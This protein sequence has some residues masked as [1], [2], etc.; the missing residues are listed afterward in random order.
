[1]KFEQALTQQK[2]LNNLLLEHYGPDSIKFTLNQIQT[3]QILQLIGKP[4]LSLFLF[5]KTIHNKRFR[6]HLRHKIFEN[7]FKTLFDTFDNQLQTKLLSHYRDIQKM[8]IK[9]A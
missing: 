9:C 7:K 6:D 2:I 8:G 5:K 3:A 4:N 1:M